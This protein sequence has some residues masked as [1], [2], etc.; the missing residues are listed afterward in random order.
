MLDPVDVDDDRN[1]SK[2]CLE[3]L[4][5]YDYGGEFVGEADDVG[6]LTDYDQ[7]GLGILDGKRKK[8]FTCT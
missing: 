1:S 7:L 4:P 2:L 8:C 6:L 3:W 5:V